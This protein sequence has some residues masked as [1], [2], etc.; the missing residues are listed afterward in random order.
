MSWMP[1]LLLAYL[2]KQARPNV[3]RYRDPLSSQCNDG[4]ELFTT[5]QEL[6]AV[7]S[8]LVGILGNRS[9]PAL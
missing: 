2:Y 6:L 8:T 5:A 1:L 4:E 7:I 3:V 9:E